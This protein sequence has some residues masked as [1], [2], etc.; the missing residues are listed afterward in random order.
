MF[1]PLQ[2]LEVR[3]LD[4]SGSRNP[5]VED[6]HML[7]F[8]LF[9]NLSRCD[10]T[11]N[12]LAVELGVDFLYFAKLADL[13]RVK[14]LNVSGTGLQTITSHAFSYM[15]Q[16][17]HLNLGNNVLGSVSDDIFLGLTDL[18]VLQVDDPRLC[19][20]H[21]H[22]DTNLEECIAPED[23]LSSCSDLLRSDF[24]RVFLWGVSVLAVTGNAGVLVYRLFLEK[25]GTSLPYRVLVMN[26]SL[27]DFFMGV[28]LAIIG[29]A[30]AEFHGQYVSKGHEWKRSNVCKIAGFLSLLSGEVSAFVICLITLDRLLVIRFPL[31]SRLRLTKWSSVL[32]C[33]VI[34]LLGLALA[35]FPLGQ[36]SWNFYGQNGIC[37]PLPITRLQFNGQQYAFGVFIALNFVLFLVIGSGQIL[38]FLSIHSSAKATSMGIRKSE[39]TIARRLFYIVL[40]DFCCWFPIGLLGVVANRGTPV[41]SVV[42]VWAAIF[43]LPLN[44]ALNPFLYTINTWLERREKKRMAKRSKY[45]LLSL[46]RE[47]RSWPPESV[48]ELGQLCQSICSNLTENGSGFVI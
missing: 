6:I 21:F 1:D 20:Y 12:F 3:Y 17:T 40:T 24:F 41:P 2:Y 48:E 28:Y 16:L 31:S 42:N 25:E 29:K 39:I 13:A 19:C 8:L 45:Q 18:R 15:K 38:I 30:D 14:V 7:P 10:L 4:L 35:S 43:V 23:E 36:D 33:T 22:E 47:L 11:G 27:S 37:V 5:L 32:S 9:L 34:W 26:L 46:Q 44:S